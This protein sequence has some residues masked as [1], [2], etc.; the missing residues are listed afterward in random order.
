VALQ[1]VRLH[2]GAGGSS[3]RKS[4]PLQPHL[5]E[6]APKFM[7]NPTEKPLAPQRRQ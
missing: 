6:V 4:V 1:H 7:T 2:E 5:L 3:Y